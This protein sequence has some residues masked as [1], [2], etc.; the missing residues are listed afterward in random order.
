M[1]ASRH[2]EFVDSTFNAPPRHAMD[3]CDAIIRRGL[4]VHLDTTNF[5]PAAAPD[6]LLALM[7]RAGFRWLGITAESASDAVLERMQKGFDAAQVRDVAARVERA[8]IGVL[9]IFLVGGPGET[10]ATLEETLAFAAERLARGD[11]V[12]LT[13]GLRIYPGTTLHAHRARR[14]HRR[15]RRSRCSCRDSTSRRSSVSSARCSGCARSRPRTR[16]SCSRRTRARRCCRISRGSRRCST[17]RGRTGAT[18]VSSSAWRAR[19]RERDAIPSSSSAAVPPGVR[20]RG[21]SRAPAR[22]VL[23]LDR[24][25]FPRDKPCAEYLSPEAIAHPRRRWAC[26]SACERAG[27]QQLAGMVVR[28][29]D[30]ARAQGSFLARPRL[31]RLPRPRARAPAHGARRDPARR[32]ARGGRAT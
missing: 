27:A 15:G 13:V 12:Y 1:P 7:R 19:S 28:A 20:P 6:E 14:G 31:P 23:L 25:R 10:T 30:G 24:A 16:A 9:W 22:A 4:R 18:W 5:T 21:T 8:G 3:V 11:A 2:F 29:P 26:S 32:R 17:C